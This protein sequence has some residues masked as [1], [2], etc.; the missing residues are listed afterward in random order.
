MRE[1]LQLAG[2]GMT[3]RAELPNYFGLL[4]SGRRPPARYFG[5]ISEF[6]R[7]RHLDVLT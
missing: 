6:I 2:F 7:G 3:T 1:E 4:G 5:A